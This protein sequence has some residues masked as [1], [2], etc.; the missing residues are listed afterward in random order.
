MG[1]QGAWYTVL[2]VKEIE[3]YITF[4]GN[5]V[6]KPRFPVLLAVDN[7][8]LSTPE[9]RSRE[10]LSGPFSEVIPSTNFLS[11]QEAPDLVIM[12]NCRS[13]TEGCLQFEREIS[14]LSW[15]KRDEARRPP[16]T[17]T[18]TKEPQKMLKREMATAAVKSYAQRC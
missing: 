7:Y 1:L 18:Q 9:V 4:R 14:S 13:P 8:S 6:I 12:A 17:H 15:R 16:P 11:T 10:L 3:K 2:P 5:G